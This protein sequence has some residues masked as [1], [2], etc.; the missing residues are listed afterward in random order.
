M[1]EIQEVVE[2]VKN[3]KFDGTVNSETLC[4]I[5]EHLRPIVWAIQIRYIFTGLFT[6]IGFI[7]L[8]ILA[9]KAIM[10]VIG[11]EYGGKKE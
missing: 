9:Y 2:I 10:A 7:F 4:E 1:K 11:Y 8:F 3:I 6:A 5:V